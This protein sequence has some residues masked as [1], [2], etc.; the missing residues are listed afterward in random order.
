MGNRPIWYSG[1]SYTNR[2][3]HASGDA[4][5][6]DITHSGAIARLARYA[7]YWG[8]RRAALAALAK[9][10]QGGVKQSG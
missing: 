2:H 4:A 8:K 6:T 9:F 1:Q 10:K 5:E 3:D 7:R